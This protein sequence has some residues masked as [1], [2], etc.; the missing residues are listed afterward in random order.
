MGKAPAFQFYV[1]DWLADP[2]LRMASHSTKGI[3]ID[4]LCFMW[5]AQERGKLVGSKDRLRLLVGAT[6]SDFDLFLSECQSLNF[7]TIII[8]KPSSVTL[9]DNN[10]TLIN[11]RMHGEY[12]NRQNTRL[13]TERWRKKR[14]CDNDVTHSSSSSSS[15]PPI[16]PVPGEGE[17]VVLVKRN[18][19]EKIPL[20]DAVQEVLAVLNDTRSEI[21]GKPSNRTVSDNITARLKEGYTVNELC[22]IVLFKATQD[23]FRKDNA[24]YLQEST[25][26]RKSNAKRYLEEANEWK[27]QTPLE[28]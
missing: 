2:E 8:S 4:L 26:F 19:S 9:S 15:I 3:W 5:E 22:R 1:R 27:D 13:R 6:E 12:I 14:K 23:H 20:K 21:T 25:L 24:M 7:A 18:S 28:N 16:S 17:R 11:R 10:V